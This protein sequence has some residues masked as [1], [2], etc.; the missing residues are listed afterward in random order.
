MWDAQVAAL[1]EHYR[2]I[3]YDVIG[4]GQSSGLSS[5]LTNGSIRDWEYLGELLD[6]LEVEKAHVVG[7]SMGGGIAI[8]FALAYPD[9]VQ[10]L[11]PMDAR[12]SGYNVPSELGDRFNQYINVSSMKG[13]QEALPLWAND[14]L[15]A[16]ANS[17]PDVR[18]QLEQMVIEDHGSLGA[19]AYFQWPNPLKIA[20]P[21]PSALSRLPQITAPT[22]AMVGE[23][24][25][26]D[27]QLQADLIDA[28]VP[29]STK[30]VVPAAGHM[31]NM[32]NSEFVNA[33]LLEFFGSHPI[34]APVSADFS[35]DGQVDAAD[36]AQWA[37]SFGPGADGDADGDGD[38]DGNDFLLWQQH[39]GPPA[40][41]SVS[42]PEPHNALLTMIAFT[43]TMRLRRSRC[44]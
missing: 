13:V 31:S 3:R 42:V 7:L 34:S 26:I 44:F 22:L 10:T 6:E 17:H 19:G 5:S 33:T 21:S 15:F 36:L 8:N 25:L 4:H 18:A 1:A 35:G 40:D 9:R 37:A 14:P 32:E 30:I 20:S 43:A 23:L 27:F 11:T 12:I 16:P 28:R 2:V 38:S 39:L 24:D 41:V 29:N